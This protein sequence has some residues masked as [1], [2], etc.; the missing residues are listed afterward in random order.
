[1]SLE[2]KGTAVSN[3]A[4]FGIGVGIGFVASVVLSIW[5]VRGGFGRARGRTRV[6]VGLG[7]MCFLPIGAAAFMPTFPAA[8]LVIL[9]NAIGY[10]LSHVVT[11]PMRHLLGGRSAPSA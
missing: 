6:L 5:A 9:G 11:L 7:L 1:M 3:A 2:R 10:A 8:L 4:A